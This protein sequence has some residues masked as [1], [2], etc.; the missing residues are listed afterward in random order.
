MKFREHPV[1]CIAVSIYRLI[2]G[3]LKFSKQSI[4]KELEFNDE[5]YTVFR[6]VKNKSNE[7]E[8][9]SCYFMVSFKFSHLSLKMNQLTS[10][11]PML[12]ITGFPGFINKMYGENE[13]NGHWLGS[14]RWQSKAHLERY[15]R[16]F[17]FRT[18]KKR[19]IPSTLKM[20]VIEKVK[21]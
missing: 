12:M 19:A 10:I 1:V 5:K 9:D 8:T 18:M 2:L 11:I 17:V 15:K 21:S 7:I 13:K 14:Y 16:S 4:G 3:N 20:K 6:H